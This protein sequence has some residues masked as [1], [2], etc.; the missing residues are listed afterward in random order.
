MLALAG[1]QEQS[2]DNWNIGA[3][4]WRLR[5][6]AL[7][8]CVEIST[9]ASS[10]WQNDMLQSREIRGYN[11]SFPGAMLVLDEDDKLCLTTTAILII[12]FAKLSGQ[13]YDSIRPYL[14]FAQEYFAFEETFGSYTDIASRP[15]IYVFLRS[16]FT[17]NRLLASIGSRQPISTGHDSFE[18]SA[19]GPSPP[20]Q[21]F[22]ALLSRISNRV[23]DVSSIEIDRWA[24]DLDFIPSFSTTTKESR[25]QPS[26]SS[27]RQQ[28]L[29]DD[30]FASL[31][32][33]WEQEVVVRELYRAAGK[34]YFF[35]QLRDRPKLS[36]TLT[37]RA[38][39]PFVAHEEIGRLT[40]SAISL[41]KRLPDSSP[42]NSALLFPLGI[43]APELRATKARR[44]TLAKLRLLQDTL[45]FDH[46]Q[47][48]GNDL[49]GRWA[50]TDA[51][52]SHWPRSSGSISRD[53]IVRLVG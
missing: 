48:F 25:G 43:I 27:P 7:Q 1:L 53:R 36:D 31:D 4:I 11:F 40:G 9:Q 44:Y 47:I 28:N 19:N 23:E 17:Y 12:L 8:G 30:S 52:A 41:L 42:F 18:H 29:S 22:L 50:Q 6:Q 49:V 37:T 32:E 15:P 34:I 20:T 5:K 14:D 16:L 3:E 45:H 33:E 39:P 10:Q 35:Q 26:I 24:G 13:A 21:N 38:F 51:D 46:F 2:S